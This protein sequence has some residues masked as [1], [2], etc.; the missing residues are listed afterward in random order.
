MFC[1]APIQTSHLK[2][3]EFWGEERSK[4]CGLDG[5]PGSR[6]VE[7]GRVLSNSILLSLSL[8]L[9]VATSTV[10][11]QLLSSMT[12]TLNQTLEV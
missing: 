12:R 5:A 4:L 2:P 9:F 3:P 7:G 8:Q 11:E 10:C 1:N 6:T